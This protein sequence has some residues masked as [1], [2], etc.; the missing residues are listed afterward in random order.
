[1]NRD[2][3]VFDFIRDSVGIQASHHQKFA[4][5]L[6]ADVSDTMDLKLQTKISKF[7]GYIE[8]LK[9]L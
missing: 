5:L 2:K 9:Q 7:N 8:S 6:K 3:P 4:N 1:M